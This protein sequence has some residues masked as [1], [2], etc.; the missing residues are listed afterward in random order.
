MYDTPLASVMVSPSVLGHRL[1]AAAEVE[2][3]VELTV[4]LPPLVLLVEVV[5]VET[6]EDDELVLEYLTPEM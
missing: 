6:V 1:V 3:V 4:E 5:E 2:E